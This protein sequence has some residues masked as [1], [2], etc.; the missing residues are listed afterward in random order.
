MQI[1]LQVDR[2]RIDLP[3][4]HYLF[5]LDHFCFSTISVHA[6]SF[7]FLVENYSLNRACLLSFESM[8]ALVPLESSQLTG[9]HLT[10]TDLDRSKPD[11]SPA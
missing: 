11:A 5:L 9:S 7:H 10:R 4:G 6:L 2:V 8:A 3:L 1:D